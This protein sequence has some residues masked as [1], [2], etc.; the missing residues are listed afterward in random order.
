M[1]GGST[2]VPSNCSSGTVIQSAMPS[3]SETAMPLPRPVIPR[4]ISASSTAACEFI[5]QAMSQA[6]T[7]TRPGPSGRPVTEAR[8]LSA[9]TSRS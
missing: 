8:P 2:P 3:K 5:P 9:C 6:E 1:R 4:W 7:P